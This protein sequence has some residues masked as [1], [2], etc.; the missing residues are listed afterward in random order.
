MLSSVSAESTARLREVASY[1][2][3]LDDQI[4]K[5]GLTVNRDLVTAKGLFFVHLYSALE[6]TVTATVRETILALS[7]L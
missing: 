7:K 5:G 3:F 1:L 6:F 4:T 2:R